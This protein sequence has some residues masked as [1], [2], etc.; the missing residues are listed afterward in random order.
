[1]WR[2]EAALRTGTGSPH[3]SGLARTVLGFLGLG[4]AGFVPV[5]G[6]PGVDGAG[7]GKSV[8]VPRTLRTISCP[9]A[10]VCYAG[11]DGG[12]LLATRDAGRPWE[13]QARGLLGALSGT[14]FGPLT[15][16]CPAARICYA[17][18]GGN[19]DTSRPSSVLLSASNGGRTWTRKPS[20]PACLEPAFACP[21]VTTCYDVRPFPSPEGVVLRTT[22]GGRSW[23]V[24]SRWQGRDGKGP[25]GLVCPGVT[26]CYAGGFDA[27]GRSRDG[28]HT[29]LTSPID[30]PSC[31]NSAD[32]CR[33]Y[34]ALAC[35]VQTV[36]YTGALLGD[37]PDDSDMFA[38]TSNSG[39]TWT[40][41]SIHGLIGVPA[42][43]CPTARSCLGLATS[44]RVS[45]RG[46][47]YPVQGMGFDLVKTTDGAKTWPVRPFMRS[48]LSPLT[49][50]ACPGARTCYAVGFLGR[51]IG[52]TDGVKTWRDLI[53]AV[54]VSGTYGGSQPRHTYS[55]WFTSAVPWRVT[56][57][58]TTADNNASC[59]PGTTIDVYVRNTR[60]QIVAGP[61]HVQARA[62]RYS[63][64]E[65]ATG[66]LRL[67]VVSPCSRF[68]VR[69]D[70]V[71]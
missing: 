51:V 37:A 40:Q 45:T 49:A 59:P 31:P 30:D 11:G 52:T 10:S 53:P 18:L 55:R 5:A 46:D 56:F 60:N 34:Q 64:V 26:S 44:R 68:S 41:S 58:T 47:N 57:D 65:R 17:P 13:W 9:T 62:G 70:G 67:D 8:T 21:S 6:A 48:A 50:I 23:D 54:F 66:V 16:S 12:V 19:C 2:Q 3:A 63:T 35:P 42:L 14:T 20:P 39:R 7:L 32:A 24:R 4:A 15:I 43:S 22:N 25:A 71:R 61:I 33:A 38:V 69:V 36:C 1:M 29:W 28:A 27:I